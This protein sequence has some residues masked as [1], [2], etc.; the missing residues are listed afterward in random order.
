M[1]KAKKK[2]ETKK[3]SPSHIQDIFPAKKRGPKL[4]GHKERDKR[5]HFKSFKSPGEK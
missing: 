2:K 5:P 4:L 3:P 1:A